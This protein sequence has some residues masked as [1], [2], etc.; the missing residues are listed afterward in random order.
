MCGQFI[1]RGLKIYSFQN[2]SDSFK[3]L[4]KVSLDIFFK[5]QKYYAL[6]SKK[7]FPK[8]YCDY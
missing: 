5:Y 3:L 2:L 6:L 7:Y 4:R 1:A 8:K